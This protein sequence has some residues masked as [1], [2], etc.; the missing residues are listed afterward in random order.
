MIKYDANKRTLS[1]KMTGNDN[2]F[3]LNNSLKMFESNL[4]IFRH[5]DEYILVDKK[6][7]FRKLNK[8]IKIKL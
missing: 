6:G 8:Q 1:I 2:I 3:S 7:K 4:Y 5:E